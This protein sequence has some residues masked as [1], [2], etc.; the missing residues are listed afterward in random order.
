M[1]A[2]LFMRGISPGRLGSFRDVTLRNMIIKEK[3]VN[4]HRLLASMASS[5]G[6]ADSAVEQ[7]DKYQ[8][9]I[10]H[11]DIKDDRN[12]K[13]QEYY[14]KHVKHLRPELYVGSD[15]NAS[16]RGLTDVI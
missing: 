3:V 16:V 12:K 15:G 13:M 9:A 11:K 14:D 7:Y 5:L 1:R 2:E 6:N 10:F 8:A 4:S